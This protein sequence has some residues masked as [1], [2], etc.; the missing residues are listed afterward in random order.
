[1]DDFHRFF[2]KTISSTALRNHNRTVFFIVAYRN[3]DSILDQIY[4]KQIF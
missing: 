1:M 2:I 3:E 4:V